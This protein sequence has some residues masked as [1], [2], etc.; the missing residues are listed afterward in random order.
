MKTLPLACLLAASV[1]SAAAA[2]PKDDLKAAIDALAAKPNYSWTAKTEMPGSQFKIPDT[3]GKTEKGGYTCA[4]SE[5]EGAT[6]EVLLKG[7]KGVVRSGDEWQTTAELPEPG[8]GGGFGGFTARALLRTK[9]PAVSAEELLGKLGEIKRGDEGVITADL[10]Q[11]GAED[12]L[13]FGGRRPGSDNQPPPP[14]NAKGTAKF[15]IKDGVLSK[16]ESHVKGIRLGRDGEERETESIRTF[17]IR[18]VGTTKIEVSAEA[19]KKL[20]A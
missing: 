11:K 1:F 5:R 2:E 7:E 3:K 20:G 12:L 18:D 9:T 14:K 13:T 17:E 4:S 8:A 19:K 16:Y 10:T 6:T 15:W